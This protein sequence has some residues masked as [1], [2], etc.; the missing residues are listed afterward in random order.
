M[1]KPVVLGVWCQPVASASSRHLLQK[2]IMRPA[3]SS[4]FKGV[5]AHIFN[6]LLELWGVA[7]PSASLTFVLRETVG[8]SLLLRALNADI[9]PTNY[10]LFS[11]STEYDGHSLFHRSLMCNLHYSAGVPAS[12]RRC[13]EWMKIQHIYRGYNTINLSPWSHFGVN[14]FS[15]HSLWLTSGD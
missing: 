14:S 7:N 2:L 8:V 4:E 5:T 1:L 13:V 11:S 15:C 12:W 9:Q 6:S 3:R 10:L